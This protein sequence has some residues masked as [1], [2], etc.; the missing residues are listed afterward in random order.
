MGVTGFQSPPGLVASDNASQTPPGAQELNMLLKLIQTYVN[1]LPKLEMGDLATRPSR[2]ISW[3][4][5]IN[6]A[7]NPLGSLAM[8]WC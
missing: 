2:L 8:D 1:D 5:G 6:L 4:T 3:K 7:L